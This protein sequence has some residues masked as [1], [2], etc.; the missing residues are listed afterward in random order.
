MKR[1]SGAFLQNG[2]GTDRWVLWVAGGGA[3]KVGGI[4]KM[5][6]LLF[7]FLVLTKLTTHATADARRGRGSNPGRW[8]AR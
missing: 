6:T 8:R 1:L 3:K 5:A 4:R 2:R 7:F